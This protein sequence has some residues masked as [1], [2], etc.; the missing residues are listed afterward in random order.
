MSPELPITRFSDMA[1]M[2]LYVFMC[3]MVIWSEVHTSTFT[4]RLQAA[5]DG[6]GCF[7]GRVGVVVHKFEV[8]EFEIV[9]VFYLR[10]NF[11]LR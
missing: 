5:L 3:V 7:D 8:L 2:A 9:D 11:H 10:I 6:D 4:R 1:A